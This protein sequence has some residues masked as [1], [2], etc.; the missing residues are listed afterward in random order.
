MADAPKASEVEEIIGSA[1][2]AEML[3]VTTREVRR[4][5][6]EGT[7]TASRV[8]GATREEWRFYRKDV[9][10]YRR[11]RDEGGADGRTDLAAVRHLERV[12]VLQQR[13]TEASEALADR[14]GNLTDLR[15]TLAAN[16]EAQAETTG[17]VRDLVTTIQQQQA[18]IAR[19]T[20]ELEAERREKHRS[21]WQRL[22]KPSG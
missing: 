22:M 10:E 7:L 13:A 15:D 2:A 11:K 9:E 6:S 3:G 14:L 21:W 4:K 19:L 12:A 5:A 16:A 20:A 18:E 1:E 17:A 8:K